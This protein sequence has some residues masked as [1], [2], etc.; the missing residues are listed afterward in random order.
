VGLGYIVGFF[1]DGEDGGLFLNQ[2]VNKNSQPQIETKKEVIYSELLSQS[3][4]S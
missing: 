4:I 3:E 1:R 2:N